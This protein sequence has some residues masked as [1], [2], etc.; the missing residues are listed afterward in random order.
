MANCPY[1]TEKGRTCKLP[2]GHEGA[3]K[4]ALRNKPLPADFSPQMVTVAADQVQGTTRNVNFVR[5]EKQQQVDKDLIAAH[6]AWI[7]AG[8]PSP[9]DFFNSKVAE[10]FTYVVPPV[11]VDPVLDMLRR[12]AG[13]GTPLRGKTFRYRQGTHASGNRVIRFVAI[14][15]IEKKLK[16]DKGS[17]K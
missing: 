16:G 1:K 3:H 17:G 6:R 8:K 9:A 12:A 11:L 2:Q 15:P 7:Q 14:D 5:D 10:R 4:T 13:A